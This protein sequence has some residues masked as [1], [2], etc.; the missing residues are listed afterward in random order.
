MREGRTLLLLLPALLV[1]LAL[2]SCGGGEDEGQGQAA[3][4]QAAQA[5]SEAQNEQVQREYEERRQAEAPSEEE[6]EAKQVTSR[7]YAILAKERAPRNPNRSMIDSAAFCELMSEEAQK[8]TIHYAKVSS[9]IAQEWN[10]E[11]A[12]DLLV[13]RSKRTGGFA[14]TRGAEVIGVN[15]EGDRA[16]ATVR[17]GKGP[18]TS[19]PLVKEDGE[20]KLGVPPIDSSAQSSE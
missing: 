9:G 7:F 14:R 11:L 17:F 10:C 13:I 8:Q 2:G 1:A 19:I 12:V 20:W 3:D 5:E 16:T 4:E 6:E 18:V 15:A